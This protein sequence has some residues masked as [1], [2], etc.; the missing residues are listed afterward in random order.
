MDTTT[1]ASLCDLLASEDLLAGTAN[2][3]AGTREVPV[4]GADSDSRFVRP[5]HVFVCK[6]AAF[7]P[8][9]LASALQKGAVAYLCEQSR[10]TELAAIAPEAPAIITSDVRRA[11]ALVAVEAWGHPD[12][13][14]DV[15]GITGTKGKSTTSYILRAILDAAQ[16]SAPPADSSHEADTPVAPAPAAAIIGSIETFD[17]IE[18][19]ESINTTPEACDLWRHIANA[20]D[21][22]LHHLVMEVSSQALK[23][24]RVVGL[25]LDVAAFLNIGR[26]HISPLEHPTWE[27]YF[28]SKL[29]IFGQARQAVVNLETDHLEEVLSAAAT[30]QK[31]VTFS[32][33]GR[34]RAGHTADVWAEDIRAGLGHSEFTVHTPSWTGSV[35]LS[36]PGTFNVDN[37]LAA[38]AICELLGIGQEAVTRG[39]AHVSVPGRMELLT[40]A[41]RKLAGIVDFAHN[42]MSFG[43][44]GPSV[45]QVFPGYQ[46]ISVFGATGDKAVERRQQLP[47]AAA[48]WSDL[49]I[50]TKDDPGFERVEDICAQMV[51]ATPAGTPTEVVPDRQAAV[52]RAVELALASGEPT[53]ICLLARGTEGFEHENGG[54]TP[55]PL[56]MDMLRSAFARFG[57][58]AA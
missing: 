20:R 7:K 47:V 18:R 32:A 6:G 1:L 17:G 34:E 29:R 8:A 46:V 53:V 30:C 42:T 33:A 45:R 57:V 12:R 19:A 14:L 31:T 50:F 35:D 10:A 48:K 26:D 25:H 5:Q 55:S 15:V 41:D 54:L 9:Y 22:R 37:A 16:V 56:D 27:D 21:S 38:I 11:M 28:A 49:L 24:D 43:K 58:R 4:T 3:D 13:T 39:L 23:Y 52:D 51:A 40:S 44:F 36:M 2:L